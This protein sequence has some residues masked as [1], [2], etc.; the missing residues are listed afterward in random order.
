MGEAGCS[1]APV[2]TATLTQVLKP[3]THWSNSPALKEILF[4]NS[5]SVMTWFRDL[6]S[7]ALWT[8]SSNNWPI[9]HSDRQVGFYF[10]DHLSHSSKPQGKGGHYG[11]TT[12]SLSKSS[13]EA[14]ELPGSFLLSTQIPLIC[15]H[16]QSQGGSSFKAHFFFCVW[17]NWVQKSLVSP[18]SWFS[19]KILFF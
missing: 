7:E 14:S 12:D 6:T 16:T 18:A 2:S 3:F 13:L 1:M 11:Y 8:S 9:L 19:F 5:V 4:K 15:L 10:I 17:S